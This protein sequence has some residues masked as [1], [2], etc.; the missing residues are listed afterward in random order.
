MDGLETESGED[1]QSQRHLHGGDRDPPVGEHASAVEGSL[2]PFLV[3]TDNTMQEALARL[4]RNGHGVAVVIDAEGLVVGSLTDAH[5]RRAVLDGHGL[6]APVAAVMSPK[7]VATPTTACEREILELMHA[8]RLSCVPVLDRQRLVGLHFLQ[9]YSEERAAPIALIM[10][11]GRGIRLRPVTDKVPKPLLKLGSRSIVERII[12][13]MVPAGV[14]QVYL[15]IN[16]L[17]DSFEERLGSGDQ[18]GVTIRYLR[19]ERA[20]GTAGALSLLP[21]EQHGPIIVSNGDIVTTVDFARLLD[22]HWRHGGAVTVAG[23]G[24]VSAIPYGVLRTAQHH[25]LSIEEKPQRRDLCS[26]GIYVLEP[27]VLR[28][29]APETPLDMP[30]LIAD[31]LA[32]GLP[33]HVFPILEKWFDIGGTAEFERMLIQFATG[34]ED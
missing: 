22:F 26:A 34:E 25:L 18:L 10:A 30:D 27:E 1:G 24:Y 19:E 9:G 31:V 7:A 23:V 20:M 15:A 33:V 13:G 4:R 5:I 11:G 17:A 32:E 28:F 8:H 12:S 2:Q 29:L 21:A 6:D 14:S 3:P 16:Y